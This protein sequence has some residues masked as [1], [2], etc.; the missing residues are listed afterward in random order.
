VLNFVPSTEKNRRQ[1]KSKKMKSNK[2]LRKILLFTSIFMLNM[3]FGHFTIGLFRAGKAESAV[4]QGFKSKDL[5]VPYDGSSLYTLK[6]NMPA[7]YKSVIEKGHLTI[8]K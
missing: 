4:S 3:A 6:N 5:F 1:L 2:R 7:E 8:L